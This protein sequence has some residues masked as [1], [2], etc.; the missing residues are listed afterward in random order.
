[1]GVHIINKH[2]QTTVRVVEDIGGKTR[3]RGG[4]E[5]DEQKRSVVKKPPVHYLIDG[6]HQ[7]VREPG[8]GG[9]I[10]GLGTAAPCGIGAQR[11]ECKRGK[12]QKTLLPI[13]HNK[14]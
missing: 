6:L 2:T 5:E 7:L 4:F 14:L 10:R 3:E 12:D 11:K 9:G 8:I 1:V 13:A